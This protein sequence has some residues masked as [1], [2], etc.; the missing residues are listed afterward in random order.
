MWSGHES[1]RSSKFGVRG[2][3]VRPRRAVLRQ[4]YHDLCPPL[5]PP[6]SN[7][8]DTKISSVFAGCV[9]LPTPAVLG[10]SPPRRCAVFHVHPVDTGGPGL[11]QGRSVR[12]KSPC[13]RHPGYQS[14]RSH[15]YYVVVNTLVKGQFCVSPLKG[16]D[17]TARNR[18]NVNVCRG[19][20]DRGRYIVRKVTLTS[21]T[22]LRIVHTITQFSDNRR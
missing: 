5:E 3:P 12:A 13:S 6:L 1:L 2:L 8:R 14:V 20:S 11:P 15:S 16:K 22:H 10:H 18:R 17:E 19:S 4:C 21:T 7:F 9:T